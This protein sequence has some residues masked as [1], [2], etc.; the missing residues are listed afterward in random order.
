[1]ENKNNVMLKHHPMGVKFT[2]PFY[3]QQCNDLQKMYM[4]ALFE[5]FFL[6]SGQVLNMAC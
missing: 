6:A 3:V 1:M 5:R 4:L 2:N